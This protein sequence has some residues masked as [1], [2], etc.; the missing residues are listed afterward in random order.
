MPQKILALDIS[1]RSVRAAAVETSFRD[2][3]VTGLYEEEAGKGESL[4]DC[5]RT[6]LSKNDLHADTVLVTLPSELATQ[7]MLTLPFRD[8]KKLSQTIPF[9]LES[10]VPFG[11]DDVIV[12]YQI[13]SRD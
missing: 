2:Y 1:S 3:K 13:L 5:L 4:T 12:D 8:K 9:E 6:I 11:L 10:Q 7:R